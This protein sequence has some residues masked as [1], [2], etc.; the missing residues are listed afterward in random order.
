MLKTC[1]TRVGVD[2]MVVL[3]YEPDASEKRANGTFLD[4]ADLAEE[5]HRGD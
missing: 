2:G 5:T 3:Q 4:F 1:T